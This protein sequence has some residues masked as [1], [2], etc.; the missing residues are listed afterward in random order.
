MEA[1][2]GGGGIGDRVVAGRRKREKSGLRG[3][4]SDPNFAEA[5]SGG[6]MNAGARCGSG[7]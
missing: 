2:G 3:K 6:R 4:I 7:G 5:G 1:G